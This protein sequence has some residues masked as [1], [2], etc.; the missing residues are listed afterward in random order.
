MLNRSLL[1]LANLS[2][3]FKVKKKLLNIGMKL[4]QK[5][6]LAEFN[7]SWKLSGNS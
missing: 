1:I 5:N 7:L 2:I 4:R 6:P 3:A